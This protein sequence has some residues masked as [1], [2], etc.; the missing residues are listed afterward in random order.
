[1]PENIR[2]QY[3][4]KPSNPASSMGAVSNVG[5]D[6]GSQIRPQHPAKPSNPASS[7]GAVSNV[8]SGSEGPVVRGGTSQPT[9][10]GQ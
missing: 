10:A 2:P 7:M 4:P 1:M 8:G 3:P 5:A 6:A 9:S